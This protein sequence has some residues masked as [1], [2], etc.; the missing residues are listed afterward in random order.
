MTR[1]R[2]QVSKTGSAAAWPLGL[3]LLRKVDER[4][5]SLNSVK[6]NYET[7]KPAYAAQQDPGP[8]PLRR[9]C[10]EPAYTVRGQGQSY[11]VRVGCNSVLYSK[12]YY[13]GGILILCL[14][15]CLIF[16][17]AFFSLVSQ[18]IP[19]DSI[20]KLLGHGGHSAS[21]PHLVLRQAFSI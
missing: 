7:L 12:W 1:Q 11:M 19:T 16:C 17:E 5:S 2:R 18:K 6:Y 14:V 20:Y 15:S 10:S 13:H 9:G 8:C 21:N 3:R 4:Q